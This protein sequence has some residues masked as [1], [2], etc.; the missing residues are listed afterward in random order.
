MRR[1]RA[2]RLHSTF[3]VEVNDLQARALLDAVSIST[4]YYSLADWMR[5]QASPLMAASIVERFGDNGGGGIY[6]T[7]PPLAE[8][9]IRIKE[10]LG[11]ADPEAPND[12]TQDMLNSMVTDHLVTTDP[13]GATMVIPGNISDDLLR[14]KLEVAARGYPQ[15]P[16]DLMPGAYTPP[17]P[18]AVIDAVD[19]AM[20][21]FSLQVH[22]MET[23][24]M[25]IGAT[26]IG[27]GS[28]GAGPGAGLAVRP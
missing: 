27:G 12:R 17:R 28:F 25:M 24:S 13:L 5:T 19:V 14:R 8:S 16:G 7:W 23:V 3:A 15:G 22:I 4:A 11:A 2:G 10:A 21:M 1:N 26:P 18:V 9:T 6:G 20:L